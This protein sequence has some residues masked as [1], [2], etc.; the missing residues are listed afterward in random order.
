MHINKV[1]VFFFL[2]A[3]NNLHSSTFFLYES[4]NQVYG[5]TL[6]IEAMY[7]DTLVDLA[8]TYNLG[9]NEIIQANPTVDKWLPGEGTLVKIPSAYILPNNYLNDGITINLSEF[10]GYLIQNS[11]L[12]TFPVGIGRMDWKT[13]LGLSE[14]DL[15]LENPAWYPPKTVRDEYKLEGLILDAIVPPGPNN[16][17]G[18][19]AMRINIPGGYFIHGTNRPD[20]V[21]MEISHG[22]IRL[23]P[24]DIK[25]VFKMSSIGT[26]VLVIDEPIKL[27]KSGNKI[28]LQFHHSKYDSIVNEHYSYLET[29]VINYVTSNNIDIDSI[30]WIKVKKVFEEKSGL[31]DQ[32]SYEDQ[33]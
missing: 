1:I 30:N 10:R 22:C 20:G 24:E 13:P 31:I 33:T 27:A 17:L 29:K 11:K 18:K 32:I 3:L 28:F 5:E 2:F 19:L 26:R 8:R 6:E 7:E 4:S 12:I 21:G 9:F 25:E 14:I 23:F 15:K 16:P